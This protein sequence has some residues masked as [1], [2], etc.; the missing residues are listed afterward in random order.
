MIGYFSWVLSK[1][2]VI[3]M[4]TFIKLIFNFVR[5]ECNWFN[6]IKNIG[7]IDTLSTNFI[8]LVNASSQIGRPLVE[9]DYPIPD[10]GSH[11]V[12]RDVA[13]A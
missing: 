10:H 3:F 1:L 7:I 12:A 5:S 9:P 4:R 8:N 13:S 2:Q 6:E 11:N